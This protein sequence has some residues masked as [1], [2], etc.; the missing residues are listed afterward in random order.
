MASY[1]LNR[2]KEV[3]YD[4]LE[5]MEKELLRLMDYD[6]K[7]K[8]ARKSRRTII[9]KILRWLSGYFAILRLIGVRIFCPMFWF[10]VI[11]D[12]GSKNKFTLMN[13]LMRNKMCG[14]Q[15]R[16]CWMVS[17]YIDNLCNALCGM[18]ALIR[19]YSPGGGTAESVELYRVRCDNFWTLDKKYGLHGKH[20]FNTLAPKL[21]YVLVLCNA[22][23][24]DVS[25]YELL[26][27]RN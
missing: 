14:P 3:D 12:A 11:R 5:G 2:E 6:A 24:K 8:A 18:D 27:G 9:G 7:A 21:E 4:T 15:Q 1:E 26:T 25:A 17:G 20:L 10:H 13:Q 19:N 23:G 16:M 22:M